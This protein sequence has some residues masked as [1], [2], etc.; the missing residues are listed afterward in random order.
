[1]LNVT[2]VTMMYGL[3]MP[4]LFPVAVVTLF[5]LYCTEKAMVYYSCRLPPMYDEKLNNSVLSLM[6]YAPL[7]LLAFGYW[8]FS[9][10]Q[11]L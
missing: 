7:L 6:T 11:L 8:M 4:V 2:F 3:G 5:I 1:M 9:N 10:N